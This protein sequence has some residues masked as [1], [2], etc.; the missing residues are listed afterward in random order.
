MSTSSADQYR[1]GGGRR[2][3]TLGAIFNVRATPRSP[4]AAMNLTVEPDWSRHC[5][6]IQRRNQQLLTDLIHNMNY[7]EKQYSAS[8]AEVPIKRWRGVQWLNTFV[9]DVSAS[10][11]AFV[12]IGR[13]CPD[14]RGTS[15]FNDL[16]LIIIVA[17]P[18]SLRDHLDRLHAVRVLTAIKSSSTVLNNP[19][20]QRNSAIKYV[21]WAW[22]NNVESRRF[23]A[24]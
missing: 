14:R 5:C 19:F 22:Q 6:C 9:D 17:R 8:A 23:G 21:K 24:D 20:H 7:T 18:A 16:N 4:Q 11:T 10:I 1:A 12:K 13:Q 3:G 15:M 2:N